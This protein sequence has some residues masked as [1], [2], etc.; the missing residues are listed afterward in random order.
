MK[1]RLNAIFVV[2]AAAV[3]SLPFFASAAQSGI[4]I[5][6]VTFDF[7][8][9]PTE[10]KEFTI[11][12]TNLNSSDLNYVIETENFNQVS[13]DGAP[14]FAGTG[15]T[16]ASV[17]TLKDWISAKNSADNS[18]VISSKQKKDIVFNVAVPAG[19]EA[20]GHYAAVF[21]KEVKKNTEGQT[22]LGVT[23]RVGSLVLVSVPGDVKKTVNLKGFSIPSFIWKGPV[24]ISALAENTGSVHYDSQV[25]VAIKPLIGAT[26][27]VDLGKHTIIPK[28][29][30]S[31]EGTWDKKFPFGYYKM[32]AS[33]SD[34][35]GAF[36]S[37]QQK[38]V[39]AIPLLIVVPLIVVIIVILLI[40]KYVKKNFKVVK[41]TSHREE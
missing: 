4:Q 22:E 28:N 29:E 9:K 37:T 26:S 2:I 23:S 35:D 21:A 20:G 38:A 16:D 41:A 6:P 13:N 1:I 40:V 24:S 36:S 5:S 33:A 25:K 34:G 14:S 12:L 32:T 18:G 17:T 3:L 10:S 7:E 15:S 11:S 30:R 27:E 39:F 31:Y 8:I 19:A